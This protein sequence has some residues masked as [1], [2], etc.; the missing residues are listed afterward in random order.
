MKKNLLIVLLIG[1]CVFIYFRQRDKNYYDMINAVSGAT[2]LAISRDVP[3]DFSLTIDGLVKKKYKFSSSAL[4]GF[5]PIRLRTREFS[6]E[7]SFLGAYAYT[8]IPVFNILE[9]IAPQKPLEAVFDQP[10]DI[11]VEFSSSSGKRSVSVSM[12]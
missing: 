6:P 3:T 2:P 12:N 4:N 7:G 8:G 11:L 5:A 1:V 9:G 10:L